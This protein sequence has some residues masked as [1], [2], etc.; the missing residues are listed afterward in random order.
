MRQL[1]LNESTFK[2]L[3]IDTGKEKAVYLKI[4]NTKRLLRLE[5][6]KKVMKIFGF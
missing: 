3:K 2:D 6:G 4:L 1:H 5:E